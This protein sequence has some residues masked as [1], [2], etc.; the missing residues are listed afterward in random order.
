MEKKANDET[1]LLIKDADLVICIYK[2]TENKVDGAYCKN[3]Q[4]M[5]GGKIK[6]VDRK[7]SDKD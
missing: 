2:S 6:V 7:Y 4:R 3:V 5:N 1:D